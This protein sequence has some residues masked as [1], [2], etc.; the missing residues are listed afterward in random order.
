VEEQGRK[1][2]TGV[3]PMRR[4]KDVGVGGRKEKKMR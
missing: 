2:R 4:R 1:R 3:V